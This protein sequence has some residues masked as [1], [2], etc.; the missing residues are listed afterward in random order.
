MRWLAQI[1]LG[2]SLSACVVVPVSPALP[3]GEFYDQ[4]LDPLADKG[5]A[6]RL[7]QAKTA[8]ASKK[9]SPAMA[10]F[11]GSLFAPG[12]GTVIGSGLAA[13]QNAS[14]DDQLA[15]IEARRLPL[16]H[17][18]LKVWSGRTRIVNEEYRVC[19]NGAERV[20][21]VKDRRFVREADGPGPCEL[22]PVTALN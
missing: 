1:L 21:T 15:A 9:I 10:S 22:T 12:T 2:C 5:A 17:E 6:E 8:I 18:L 16:K 13:F 3:I 11:I 20:Y 7:D 4:V 19:V 14:I